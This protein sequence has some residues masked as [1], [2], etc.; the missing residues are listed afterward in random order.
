ML[1][2]H[3][4]R[5]CNQFRV[6]F[7]FYQFNIWRKQIIICYGI[8]FLKEIFVCSIFSS[9]EIKNRVIYFFGFFC[10]NY[11][12]TFFC[13]S[14]VSN[15]LLSFVIIVEFRIFIFFSTLSSN[16]RFCNFSCR[17]YF[18]SCKNE[19]FVPIYLDIICINLHILI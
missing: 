19:S 3:L 4:D 11:T 17:I 5:T 18:S 8:F 12:F 6:T 7:P 16:S 9:L 2:I 1:Q 14:V 15:G 10:Y 13:S